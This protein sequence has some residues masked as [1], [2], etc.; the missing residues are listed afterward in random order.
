[1]KIDDFPLVPEAVLEG[2]EKAFPLR[3]IG[4]DED[5]ESIRWRAAQR[6]VVLYLRRVVEMQTDNTLKET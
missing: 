1:M 6:S 5:F 4:E 3:E 2:L